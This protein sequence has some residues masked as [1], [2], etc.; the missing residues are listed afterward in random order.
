[1]LDADN[2]WFT[3]ITHNTNQIHF[4]AEYAAGTEFG[5]PLVNSLFTPR[6]PC[7]A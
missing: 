7:T 2:F 3:G 1:L 4:N 6:A 5:K